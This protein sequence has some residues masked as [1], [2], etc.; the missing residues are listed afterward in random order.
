MLIFPL[1]AKEVKIVK[2]RQKVAA[3]LVGEF[4]KRTT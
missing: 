2:K 4:K 3:L 1:V